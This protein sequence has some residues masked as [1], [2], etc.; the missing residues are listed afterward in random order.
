MSDH[1]TNPV[2]EEKS[3]RISD[4]IEQIAA[5]NQLLDRHKELGADERNT[6]QY[7]TMKQDFV[8]ELNEILSDF[9]L[10]V[11]DEDQAA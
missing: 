9:K 3:A 6:S 8:A 1:L 10:T 7:K 2:L 4:I 5:L 11:K